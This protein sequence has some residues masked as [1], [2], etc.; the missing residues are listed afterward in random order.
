MSVAVVL[1]AA[2]W[3]GGQPS[4]T[5]RRRSLHAAELFRQGR[6]SHVICC[7]GLGQHPPSEAE[8]MQQICR[9]AGVPAGAILL[10]DKSHTTHENLANIQPLLAKLEQPFIV[11]VTD[12]YHKWRALLVARH[13]GFLA[14]ASCPVQSGTSAFRVIKSWLREVPAL[15]YYWWRFR[16]RS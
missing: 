6:V 15:I 9:E 3:P 1:G 2:V 4:P 5:L 14:Q 10:E 12:R 7:G 8:V 16:R 11:I 13:L